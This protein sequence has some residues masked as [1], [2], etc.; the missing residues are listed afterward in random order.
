M[1]KGGDRRTDQ[2]P[3]SYVQ[4]PKVWALAGWTEGVMSCDLSLKGAHDL[5]LFDGNSI[6]IARNCGLHRYPGEN[7][8]SPER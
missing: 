1:P 2:E 7:G 8:P 4:G 3:S 6:E 5:T